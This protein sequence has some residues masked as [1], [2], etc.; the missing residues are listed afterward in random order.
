MSGAE[1]MN[2]GQSESGVHLRVQWSC[3]KR[4]TCRALRL[5]RNRIDAV[6]APLIGR[7]PIVAEVVESLRPVA[8]L[9]RAPHRCDGLDQREAPRNDSALA[10]IRAVSC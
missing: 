7:G 3:V 6:R 8:L 4:E 10:L 5:R 1:A 9:R 2:L